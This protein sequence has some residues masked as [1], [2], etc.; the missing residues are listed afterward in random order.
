MEFFDKLS[1]SLVSAGKDVSQ[2][3]K[4]VSEIAK[5]KLDIKSKED[6]VQKQYEELGR[7]YYEKHKD[8]EE[9]EEAE[10]FFLIREAVEEIERMK[11]RVLQ[12]VRSA[13]RRCRKVLYIAATVVR[14][15]MICMRKS[16]RYAAYL[17][18][19][20]VAVIGLVYHVGMKPMAGDD[21]FFRDATKD[22]T[23]WAYLTQRYLTWTSRVVSECVLVNVIQCP[24][25]W[26]I[27]DFLLFA[28]L[29]LLLSGL[30]GGGKMMNWC[31][32][33]AVLIFPFH[34]MG[35]AGWITTTVTHFWPFWGFFYVAW[36]IR[37]LALA[38][39]IHPAAAVSAVPVAVVTGS[40]EQY[41]VIMTL[42][43]VLSGVYLWKAHR[44]PGNAVLFWTLAVIDVVSLL[45]IALC[46]GNAGRNAVSIADLPVYATFGFGQKLYLGL[47]SIER[48]FI[49]NADIVFFLVVLIWT[50]LV[51]E[52][53]KDYRRTF[54]S[55]L[56]L[57]IL[58]GQ[59][60]LRTAYPGLSGLFVMPGEILEW[61]W[62]DLSTWIPMV[63]LAVTVAAMIY[64]LYQ[65]FGDD[66]FTFISV[67]LL[68]GC[69][70]GAGMVLGFM[71]TIYVSGERVY[72]PLYGILLAVTLF[73]ICRQRSVWKEPAAVS[74]AV[75]LTALTVVCCAVNVLFIVLSL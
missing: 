10:Q 56:P 49:A 29:P 55:A 15:W 28:T 50:W 34:D 67:L 38:E 37:K 13:V 62:S 74:S 4:D 66:L 26:R 69:G 35:T 43:L 24:V 41:A 73:G 36:V 8:E 7:S 18:F 46:P 32:A 25:L 3:A 33:A 12:N 14:R 42:L 72:A 71:A 30:F 17:P 16:S 47:L 70:F 59:T 68:V 45:V 44:R 58:F 60:V 6:Y 40:H 54:L 57:L 5:L 23:L 39:K 22:T 65:L 52:K 1:E 64:A 21:I 63:Y 27:I 61:S 19:V 53:T 20:L 11:S 48:V 31:A 51:W 2:K 75:F 9:C